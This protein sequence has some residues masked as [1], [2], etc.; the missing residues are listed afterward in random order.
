MYDELKKMV[1]A[2]KL[3]EAIQLVS[4]EL[5]NQSNTDYFNTIVVISGDNSSL[6]QDKLAGILRPD[7]ESVRRARITNRFLGFLDQ[8]NADGIKLG[9]AQ[10][11]DNTPTNKELCAHY[12]DLTK[13]L[14]EKVIF[15]KK[16]FTVAVD[17]NI[18]FQLSKTL[19]ETE[20]ELE[21]AKV[22]IQEYCQ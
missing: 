1:M 11:L 6:E 7:D 8:M 15:L 5:A 2:R 9:E 18:R 14:T 16:E 19:E 10:K 21:K 22:G 13:T 20:V 4:D 3:K 17:P 12:S